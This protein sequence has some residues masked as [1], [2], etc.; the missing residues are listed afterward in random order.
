[1]RVMVAILGVVLAAVLGRFFWDDVISGEDV[2]RG[3]VVEEISIGNTDRAT[4]AARLDG[5]LALEGDLTLTFQGEER[6]QS[7]SDWGVTLDIEATIDQAASMRG[8]GVVRFF[9]WAAAVI[10][11]R[12]TDPVWTIDS[13]ILADQF[14]DDAL[15]VVFETSTIE[16]VDDVFVPIESVP[17]PIVDTAALE[18]TLSLTIDTG[19]T[20][21]EV[22]IS[23]VEKIAGD[24]ALAAAAN[25]LTANDITVALAGTFEVES[26]SFR[27]VRGWLDV[28]GATSVDDFSFDPNRVQSTLADVFPDVGVDGVDGV[29]FLVGF[30]GNPILLGALEGSICC[31]EDTADKLFAALASDEP[32][33]VF[34]REDPDAHG[35]QWASRLGINELVG[36]F[37][38]FY[39]P[40]QTRNINIDRI[41]ELTR[42]V[43]IAPGETFSVNDY[44]GP[45][46]TANG[47][48]SAGVIS[49]GVFS[50]SVGG[51]ISQYATT[52][53]NAAFFAG[54]DFGEYQS[55]S[56]YISRY[57]FGRE[58]TVSFPAP[59]LQIV[60]TTPYG[61]LLWPTTSDNSITV[62][63][64][65]TAY[66]T[67][68]QTAQTSRTEGTSCTRVNT[69]RTR[70]YV[71]D[72]RVEVDSVTA[73]YRAE[74]INCAGDS[75][76]PT[77]TTTTTTTPTTVP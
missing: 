74:G 42:G 24:E 51:G 2:P 77:T 45:R 10:R 20:T 15:G 11:D 32:V 8:G 29:Q 22:P 31:A 30:D 1:M 7:Y 71:D 39:T 48:V 6:T 60:N 69:E 75:T 68:E 25:E 59:D 65:S 50:S 3:V 54:L 9:R 33:T 40:N 76:R 55:H 73:R 14:D 23:G 12:A 72:G 44:V 26:I 21:I 5:Q 64:Y 67:S 47:F 63:L 70:T 58:A 52:V 16:L 43:I 27:I 34:P 41:S 61:V 19:D 57:P 28:S 53:F 35:L 13:G 18:R 66:V 56:I 46:T 37:T 4:A 36:E 17:R 38:T 49:N 62:R